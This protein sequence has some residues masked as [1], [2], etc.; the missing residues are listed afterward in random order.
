MQPLLA[1]PQITIRSVFDGTAMLWLAAMIAVVTEYV[2]YSVKFS[3]FHPNFFSKK[4][5]GGG[6]RVLDS[7][8]GSRVLD[9]GGGPE[10][11]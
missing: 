8:G 7:G 2:S 3:T 10:S 9:S 5:S 1:S 11:F 6:S 4:D